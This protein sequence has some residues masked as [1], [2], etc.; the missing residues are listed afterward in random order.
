MQQHK[1]ET[2]NLLNNLKQKDE[3]IREERK[4]Q[5]GM[6]NEKRERLHN[7]GKTPRT[8]P[9]PA[10]AS[11]RKSWQYKPVAGT[12]FVYFF[13]APR[14]PK[15]LRKLSFN[16]YFCKLTYLNLQK[17]KTVHFCA[18]LSTSKKK[19]WHHNDDR[20]SLWFDSCIFIHIKTLFLFLNNFIFSNI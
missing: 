10:A 19:L 2:A 15:N 20:A 7:A 14:P 1:I 17:S 12:F 9:A 11:K 13:S 8:T 16:I 5:L 3:K 6:L 18:I 4:R